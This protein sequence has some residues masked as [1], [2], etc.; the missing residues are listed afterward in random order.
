METNTILSLLG[1]NEKVFRVTGEIVETE[2]SYLIFVET[3]E[4]PDSRV[5]P[6]CHKKENVVIKDYKTC[7]IVHSLILLK[8]KVKVLLKKR[9]YLCKIV[10]KLLLKKLI[11]ANHM[12]RYLMI[13]C[14]QYEINFYKFNLFPQ[15]L[16]ISN[17][18]FLQLSQYLKKWLK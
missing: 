5:C 10:I 18:Q 17:Y 7:E 13:L 15:L 3:I 8:K 9:R 14:G 2:D 12:Q 11:F 4:Q 16:K 6:Y 1:L